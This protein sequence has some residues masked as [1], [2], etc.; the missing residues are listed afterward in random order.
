M[1]WNYSGDPSAS[2][3]D[4]VRFLVQDTD[5]TDQLVSDGEVNYALS[6]EGSAFRAAA[7]ICDAIALKLGRQMDSKGDTSYIA[8]EKYEQ[9]KQMAVELRT[10]ASKS[11]VTLFA[12]GITHSQKDAQEQDRDRVQPAFTRELHTNSVLPPG[13]PLNER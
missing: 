1:S 6:T 5:T 8:R 4:E 10:K 13:I 3:L 11:A 7:S 9:Y 2:P 12:G